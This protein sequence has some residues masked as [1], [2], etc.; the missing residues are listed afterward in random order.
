[1]LQLIIIHKCNGAGNKLCGN[2]IAHMVLSA[3]NISQGLPIPTA[4][5]IDHL[6]IGAIPIT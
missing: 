5:L 2:A 6:L 3:Q 1:M 4:Q